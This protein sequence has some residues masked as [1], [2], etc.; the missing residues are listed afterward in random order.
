MRGEDADGAAPDVDDGAVTCRCE[1]CSSCGVRPPSGTEGEG[2]SVRGTHQHER[3]RCWNEPQRY[4]NVDAKRGTKYEGYRKLCK[5]CMRRAAKTRAQA[6]AEA[7]SR[8]MT[9]RRERTRTRAAGATP[10]KKPKKRTTTTTTTTT[11]TDAIRTL[12]TQADLSSSARRETIVLFGDSLTERSFEEG[13]F[14]AAIANEY[15][16]FADVYVRGYSGYNTTHALC[17]MDDVFPSGAAPVLVTV[18]FGSNDACDP[19]SAAG[20]VQHVPV[21]K[22]EENLREMVRR[23]RRADRAPR[24]L[25]ITPPPVHDEAWMQ[26]CAERSA[27]PNSGFGALLRGDRPNRTNAGIKPYVAAMKRVAESMRVPLVDL[28]PA[29][30]FSNG[31]VDESQFVDGLHFSEAGQR[32]VAAL[33]VDAIREAFPHLAAMASDG[34]KCDYPDWKD[35]SPTTYAAQIASH[36]QSQRPIEDE[37]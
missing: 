33:V 19:H 34:V 14:G 30:H 11:T 13:G 1:G 16:R 22:Y 21:D 26:N 12:S 3:A 10:A 36:Y 6:V 23:I 9:V 15:R 18:L 20:N 2:T 37:A 25:F 8:R 27:Q 4:T 5:P 35:L 29:L 17:V 28:H 7:E 31:L 24:V 32:Q